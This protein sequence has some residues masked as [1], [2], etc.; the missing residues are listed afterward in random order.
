MFRNVRVGQSECS[1]GTGGK[2]IIKLA[3][4]VGEIVYQLEVIQIYR[5]SF[6]QSASNGK[7]CSCVSKYVIRTAADTPT[8]WVFHFHSVNVN[9]GWKFYFYKVYWIILI[10]IV[11]ICLDTPHMFGYP[12]MLRHPHMFGHCHIFWCLCMFWCT[13]ICLNAPNTSVCPHAALCI[14]MFLGGS[15]IWHG[16]GSIYTPNIECSGAITRIIYKMH[17]KFVHVGKHKYLNKT[18]YNLYEFFICV[19]EGDLGGV[20]VVCLSDE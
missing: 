20:W 8:F 1:P 5:S 13:A 9:L 11:C 18:P 7:S 4:F 3:T 14:C 10:Y 15:S 2:Q 19:S 16:D 6:P 17:Y 12:I